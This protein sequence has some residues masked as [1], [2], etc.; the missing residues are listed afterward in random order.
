MQVTF[1]GSGAAFSPTAYNASILVDQALLLDAGAPL[2]VHLPKVGVP[3]DQP[4][5]VFISHFHADHSFNLALLIA[6]RHELFPASPPLAILGPRGTEDWLRQLLDL[7]WG[8]EFRQAAW[9]HLALTVQELDE[10]RGAEVAG[11]RVRAFRMAHV[12]TWACLGYLLEKDGVRLGYTGDSAPCPGLDALVEA[13]TH[14]IA[15]MTYDQPGKIHLSRQEVEGLMRR[16]P[17]VRFILTHRG[18]DQPLDGAVL[19][20]DFLTL[21]LP[22]A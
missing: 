4:A 21:E 6:A 5:A 8:E 22:L 10:G 14:V 11:Y 13:S 1:L 2:C 16:H 17:A 7:A 18:S 19:A 15:E 3:L 20:R 12:S 9:K